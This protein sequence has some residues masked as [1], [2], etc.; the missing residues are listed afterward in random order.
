[1]ADYGTTEYWEERY[2][3][4]SNPY[5]WY[6]RWENMR[7]IIKEYLKFDDKILVVGNGTSRLPEE[8]YDDGYQ[9]IEAMDISTVAVEIMHERFASR[10]IPCQ[11]GN[12]LDMYQYSDDGYDV[13]IDKGTFDSILCGENSHINIDTMMRE[14]VRVLNYDKGRY[15]CISYG[16]PNYR[17]NY[18]KSMKEWE[19]T[20]IPIKKPAND[21]IY[22]LKNY[23]DEDSNSQENVNITTSTRPDLYHYIY[24]CTVVNKNVPEIGNSL[25]LNDDE[26]GDIKTDNDVELNADNIQDPNN[27]EQ[28]LG[29][30]QEDERNEFQ[31]P[32]EN[33]VLENS[34]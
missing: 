13:V 1:M 12:V 17:L 16:Q 33:K 26:N 25:N 28:D 8:I 15:I 3:K 6:Q 31:V 27:F 9:S 11:V 20:T 5:D 29:E 2:K 19:V 32:D 10:N 34:I 7:E 21:Q 24:I 4:D 23:N 22:K 30:T 18:L 14:L